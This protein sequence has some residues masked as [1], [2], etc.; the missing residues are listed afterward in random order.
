MFVV[1]STGDSPAGM[2]G[3]RKENRVFLVNRNPLPFRPAS[4]RAGRAGRPRYPR[5][6]DTTVWPTL[7]YMISL[8]SPPDFTFSEAEGKTW[9]SV[10]MGWGSFA[11][12][13]IPLSA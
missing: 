11:L 1:G 4:C 6:E 5:K 9:A 7:H 10:P 12:A 8:N 2:T 13:S 3:V